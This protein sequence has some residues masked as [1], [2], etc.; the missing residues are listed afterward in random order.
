M[1]P[2]EG[3]ITTDFFEPRPLSKP[4]DQR[5]HVHGAIDIGAPT[6][7]PIKAPESGSAF[8]WMS[9]R[10]EEGMY[11]PEI[12]IVNDF[13]MHFRNYFYDTFGGILVLLA[14]NNTHII[15]HSYAKQIFES[16]IF[17]GCHPVEEKK[18]SRF[19]IL[20]WYT[21]LKEVREGEV[22]GRV[23]NAGYSTG[24]HIHWEIH[25]GSEWYPHKKRINPETW[26]KM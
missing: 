17:E 21:E 23:G 13:Q 10:P 2:T 26:L 15:T 25:P 11:W 9:T 1:I 20:G 24:S 5:D 3:P 16:R 8:G 22:I 4:L 14:K 18:D 6:S 19:P 12:P 7:S